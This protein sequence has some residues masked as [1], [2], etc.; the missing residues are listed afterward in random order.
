MPRWGEA[1]GQGAHLL[2][3]MP[4]HLLDFGADGRKS[5]AV[6][7]P[8][9]ASVCCGVRVLRVGGYIPACAIQT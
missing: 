8:E 1:R 2:R 3:R 7:L 9:F 5:T 6:Q 4:E